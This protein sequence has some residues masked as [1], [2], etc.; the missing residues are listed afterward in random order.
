MF[1]EISA[2][3]QFRNISSV[4]GLLLSLGKN[5]DL[6]LLQRHYDKGYKIS[7]TNAIGEF[8]DNRNEDGLYAGFSL[9]PLKGYKLNGYAD[10]YHS[11]W[12]RYLVDAPSSGKDVMLELQF[13]KRKSYSWY[14][15]YRSE[16]KQ[17][18]E[19]GVQHLN[20]MEN[21]TRTQFRFHI[22]H[23]VSP[24]LSI[25]S[26]IEMVK[27]QLQF[28]KTTTGFMM[29]QDVNIALTRRLKMTGRLMYFD[30]QDYDARI[31]AYEN[32]MLYSYS[33]PSFQ[34][35]GTRFYTLFKYK[36]KRNIDI[37]TRFARTSYENIDVIG[38]GYDLIAGS[39]ATDIKIQLRWTL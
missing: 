35:R 23:N 31:Y 14:L 3:E 1:G 11:P 32:D 18:N 33:V 21:N 22:E 30:V 12:Y 28:G 24:Q 8:S 29:F 34:N 13:A 4:N 26:R 5:L 17:M 10:L 27:Y 2:N 38:S 19:E 7:I 25:R 6:S 15:R 20:R 36:L 16:V 39:K 37:W 9:A